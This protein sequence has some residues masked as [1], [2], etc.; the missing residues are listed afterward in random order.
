MSDKNIIQLYDSLSIPVDKN[1]LFTIAGNINMPD[2]KGRVVWFDKLLKLDRLLG[3]GG[4]I[5]AYDGFDYSFWHLVKYDA[6]YRP[7]RYVYM[8]ICMTA[9]PSAQRLTK[10]QIQMGWGLLIV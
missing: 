10:N 8:D 1:E 4:F 9:N 5:P 2:F 7:I 3:V 6:V